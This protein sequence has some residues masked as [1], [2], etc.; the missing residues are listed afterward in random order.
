MCRNGQKALG[1]AGKLS[2][3]GE[4]ALFSVERCLLRRNG[5]K[6]QLLN[7]TQTSVCVSGPFVASG[8]DTTRLGLRELPLRV[9]ATTHVNGQRRPRRARCQAS[10]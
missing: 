5:I 6:L 2:Q 8:Q 3:R 7:H 9:L 10:C 1:S 4:F